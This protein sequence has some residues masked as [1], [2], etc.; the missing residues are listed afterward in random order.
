MW[1]ALTYQTALLV[2]LAAAAGAGIV[3]TYFFPLAVWGGGHGG[4]CGHLGDLLGLFVIASGV[5]VLKADGH[6]FHG[7]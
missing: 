1:L 2:F 7:R 4:R 5:T 3:S 6:F